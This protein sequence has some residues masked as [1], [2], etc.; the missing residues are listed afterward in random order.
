[1]R[2]GI[3]TKHTSVA[4]AVL[5]A[6]A[7][8]TRTETPEQLV[9]QARQYEAKGDSKAAVIQLKNALQQKPDDAPARLALGRLYVKL[10]DGAS[11]EKELQHAL[12]LDSKRTEVLPLLARALLLQNKAQQVLDVTADAPADATLLSLRGDALL[13]LQQ[14][15]ASRQAYEAALKLQPNQ[16]D[17]L[18]GLARHALLKNDVD[19]AVRLADSAVTNNPADVNALVFQG[20]LEKAL[21]K[22]DAARTAYDKALRL[23]PD[24]GGVY[25]QKAYLEIGER[26]LDAARANLAELKKVAP[27]NLLYYHARGLLEFTEGKYKD[28]LGSVQNILKVAPDHMPSVLLAGAVQFA[29]G[30]LPQAEQHLKQYVESD[31]GNLY[32]RKMLASVYLGIKRPADALA[33]LAAAIPTSNDAALLNIGARAYMDLQQFDKAAGTYQRAIQIA[34]QMA[35]SYAGLGVAKMSQGDTDGAIAAMK[36]SI[37][38][39]SPKAIDTGIVLAATQLQLK[40]SGAALATLADM[41]AR[42]PD[43]PVLYNLVGAAKLG[44]N[45]AA[46]ARAAFER[47][48]QL[49]PDF[50]LPVT[51]LARLDLLEN[52]PAAARQ[53]FEA[54]VA[55][56]PGNAEALTALADL[57]IAANDQPAATAWLEKA[58]AADPKQVVPGLRLVQQYMSSGEKRK[59]LT[60]VRNMQ[61]ANPENP[62]VLDMLG[63]VQFANG[64][65][66][67]AL[68][69]YSRLA[70]LQPRTRETTARL[71]G[72]YEALGERD[73]AAD[74]L[75]KAQAEHPDD[76]G[77]T[78][79]R[80][81]VESRRGNFD[82]AAQLAR[83]AQARPDNKVAGLVAEAEIRQLQRKPELAIPLYER[84][85]QASKGA[86]TLRIK[87]GDAYRQAGRTEEASR[88][89]QQWRR[90]KP[91][92]MALAVYLGELHMAQKQYQPAIEQFNVVLK[93]LP[94]NGVV[95]NNLALAYQA[96]A[97]SRALATAE[98]AHQL[99]PGSGA[100]ADTLGWLLVEQGNLARG[101]PLLKQA[102]AAEPATVDI[103]YHLAVALA[104]G[105]D[106]AGA[107]KELEAVLAG[108]PSVAQADQARALLKQL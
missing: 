34:P 60:L 44:Q 55:K 84:A 92:D 52:K 93:R 53:R 95:L 82:V 14:V 85:V 16:G 54:F 86:T 37:T 21:G 27:Q 63:G 23:N 69:A 91:D 3:S 9:A 50:V 41:Q 1:M 42:Q 62:A 43:N 105:S 83:D 108:K 47:A 87:L 46:G 103:R 70:A 58:S 104:R 106:K 6:L 32:A 96:T 107:R 101:V 26:K 30:S 80:A 13:A 18:N 77:I 72:G 33:Q 24:E 59:A 28:A 88:L 90:E 74:T 61:V 89:V 22:P 7:G 11:A 17:A 78:L 29:L 36:K 73:L 98:R 35:Q 20:D 79:A 102:V 64:E 49:K 94:D 39:S 75:R 99:V 65:K 31:P 97:D 4:L 40:Q 71:A 15:D 76:I 38:L 12:T 51:N 100:I 25:L 45:D 67:A 10:G 48:V 68:E 57:A 2:V 66:T 56:N 19:G 8:C 5:L 81:A